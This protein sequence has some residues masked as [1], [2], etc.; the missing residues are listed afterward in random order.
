MRWT[1]VWGRPVL[2]AIATVCGLAATADAIYLDQEQNIALRARIYS[3]ASVRTNDSQA[4][5]IPDARR[6]QLVEHRNFYNPE[7]DAKLTSYTTWMK[8]AGLGFLAPDDFSVRLAA[9]GFYDGAYDYG[10]DQFGDAVRDVNS[11]Y[12]DLT[13]FP[14]KAWY[15]EGPTYNCNVNQTATGASCRNTYGSLDEVFPGAEVKNARDIYGH[16]QRVNELYFNY[17]KGPVFF[18]VGRQS[19][20]WGEADTIGLLDQNNPFDI[21]LGAPGV[22][23]DLEESRIPLWTIRSTLNLFDNLGPF[24]SGFVEA[25]WVPGD[26]DNNTGILPIPGAS[27][28]SVRQ[29]DPQ[30]NPIIQQFN[31]GP[32]RKYQFVLIDGV[33][34]KNFENSRYGFRAQTVVNQ[35]YTVSAWFYTHFP[36]APVPV[37]EAVATINNRNLF[38]VRTFRKLTSVFGAAATFFAEPLDSI[39]RAEVEYFENEPG[40]I[41][42]TNLRLSTDPANLQAL[43]AKGSVPYSDIIRWELGL[44]RFF[45][46]RPL[47]PSN[48]FLIAAAIVG[49]YNLD[50]TGEKDFR[51][52]GQQKAGKSGQFPND[53][54]QQKKVEAFS[55]VH[56][57]TDYMH[58]RLAPG[59]TGIFNVRGT[60]ALLP[61]VT[62]R[63]TDW[64]L[65]DVSYVHIGGEYQQIGFF[66]DRD[67]I[68]TRV[69][70]QLN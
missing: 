2:T 20:S 62:Y 4:D 51:M 32:F 1:T 35:A 13:S 3:R 48:S 10:A 19:I 24:S 25:Y 52:S 27:P 14:T 59:F 64:L 16:R 68:A 53:F 40:F 8:D 44:D 46:L 42:D 45:F 70:Y 43:T 11:T 5:T 15:L 31:S 30:T 38:V 17:S 57:Q 61:T 66:R 7:L 39:I 69:T 22:F 58:G 67:Q 50:E 41:P 54:V 47:N 63:F 33:P 36:N 18:R 23:Q 9:W 56:L 60:Y 29:R 6:G 12:G 28:Y 34:K 21:T 26:L 65:F 49:A 37:K 55:Q